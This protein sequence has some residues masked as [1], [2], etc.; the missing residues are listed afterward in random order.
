VAELWIC[1]QSFPFAVLFKLADHN[2]LL[3]TTI[4]ICFCIHLFKFQ[5]S[6]SCAPHWFENCEQC[7]SN[8]CYFFHCLLHTWTCITDIFH[9]A[10]LVLK[11]KVMSQERRTW[12]WC[13]SNTGII[14]ALNFFWCGDK[15][16]ITKCLVSRE[17]LTN[18]AMVAS[19]M[20][21]NFTTKHPSFARI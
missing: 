21:W 14:I 17:E 11:V 1:D 6:H 7:S 12:K 13:A 9:Q 19:K 16:P 3:S 10:V 5:F 4:W 18:D 8:I 20:K 2:K 15:C